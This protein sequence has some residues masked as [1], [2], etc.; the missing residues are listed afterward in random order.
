MDTHSEEAVESQKH[1]SQPQE[2][3]KGTTFLRTCFNGLNA[4]SGVG[5][6]SIPYALSQGGWLSLII[7]FLVA[8]LCCYTGL[9]LRR[10]MDAKPLIKTFP[11]IGELAF[12]GKGRA[13]I[14]TFMYLELFLVAV[15]FLILEGDNLNKLFPNTS[16][17]IA[18][19]KIGGKRS[20]VLLTALIILPTTWLR[21]LGLLAYVSAGG[22]LASLLLVASVFWAG[23]VDG[24]GFHE[25]GMLLNWRGIPTAISLFTFCYCGHA[26]FPT[27][28]N[29]MKDRSQFPK[30]LLVCF[31]LSTISYG[32]MAVLGYLMYGENLMS[33]VTLNLP[34]RNFS[35]KIAIYTTLI[36]PITKYAIVVSP[37]ATAIEDTFPFQNSRLFSFVIR[38][39]LV[40]STVFVA[41]AIPFFG[42]VMAFTGAFLSI[43]VSILFP[44]FCYLK[45][46]KNSI[47]LGLELMLI[48]AIIVMG[49]LVAVMVLCIGQ[50][51]DFFYFV[52]QWPGSYC[53]TKQSCC[54]P[55]TGK[56][57]T[58][59]GIHGLWPNY[60]DG[61]YPS[62][63]DPN[64][65]YNQS[66]ISDLISRL[67]KSWPTLACPSGTGSSFWSHEWVKHGTCSESILTQHGYF[68]STL[69][70][71]D[72]LN[73]LQIL[74]SAGIEPDGGFYSLNSITTA[75]KQ[76]IGY[77]PGIECNVD[78]SG[79]SQLYQIYICVD[80]SGSKII[81]CPV[82]PSGRCA[83]QIEFPSF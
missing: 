30:V 78:E 21:S 57:A 55:T 22:V 12:G 48:M 64:S 62:D 60:N 50:D 34:T 51:F 58:D 9:L 4:L 19:Q 83:S 25:K 38:T 28:C 8:I 32:S 82:L 24:V 36:N 47:S 75:I 77:T 43:T 61:S 53:D 74:Q 80:K 41:L 3:G 1:P 46:K 63:C 14:S 27:L 26:V 20:F 10:C 13:M 16:F 18:G 49:F 72:K 76:A 35:S 68:K 11:D 39:V 69:D 54:Y 67:Q 2:P 44:C 71:K 42:Y 73:L 81:Q 40:I 29:S 15:E 33:Q 6:L 56:P 5:M 66:K 7:L 59:F 23:A 45:I 52:Q 31:V 70:L 17:H 79:N 65:P 37:I